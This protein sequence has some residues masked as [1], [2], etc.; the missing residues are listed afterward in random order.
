[1]SEFLSHP[2]FFN[3]PVCLSQDELEFPMKVINQFFSDYSLS[4]VRDIHDNIGEVCLTSDSPPFSD[5]DQRANFLLYQNNVIRFFE[6]VFVLAE[7]K[8]QRKGI[9]RS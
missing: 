9:P 3:Q 5:G 4:E 1:M 2:E 6:A 8:A 7:I